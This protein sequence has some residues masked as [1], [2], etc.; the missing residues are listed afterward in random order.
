[1]SGAIGPPST[2]LHRRKQKHLNDG[3]PTQKSSNYPPP[4]SLVPPLPPPLHP[5]RISC[6]CV[7]QK[8]RKR[9]TRKKSAQKNQECQHKQSS[10]YYSAISFAFYSISNFKPN[11]HHLPRANESAIQSCGSNSHTR[12]W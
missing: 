5:A 9:R 2:F 10:C 6:S 1:M 3:N 11:A 12:N 4:S 7:V 8:E